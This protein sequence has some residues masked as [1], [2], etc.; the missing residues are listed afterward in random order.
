M[1]NCQNVLLR[2]LID[3]CS[4]VLLTKTIGKISKVLTNYLIEEE[5]EHLKLANY[6]KL[7]VENLTNIQFIL[8]R[9]IN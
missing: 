4:K 3:A 5:D 9:L 8:Y 7:R 1:N 2:N 6:L